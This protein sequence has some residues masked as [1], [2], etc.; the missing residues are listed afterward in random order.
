MNMNIDWQPFV[1]NARLELD[2]VVGTIREKGPKRFGKAFGL[3]GI[4]AAIAYFGIYSRLRTSAAQLSRELDK[5]KAMSEVGAQYKEIRDQLGTAYAILPE[6]SDRD[7]WLSNALMD[8]LRARSLTP[9]SVKPVGELENNGL[10]LQTS[11]V[12][13]TLGFEEL[14]GLI[15]GIEASKPLMHIQSFDLQKKPD[16]LGKNTANITVTT[17]IPKKRLN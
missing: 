6:I 4:C 15:A 1:K 13:L 2:L 12:E 16:Q 8:V 17:V 7:Q 10:I 11:T 5:V 14:Y 3:A 9:D